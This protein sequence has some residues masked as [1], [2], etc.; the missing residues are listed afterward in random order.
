MSFESLTR[1]EQFTAFAQSLVGE[2]WS[3]NRIISASREMGF[4]IARSEALGIVRDAREAAITA[5]EQAQALGELPGLPGLAQ[6]KWGELAQQTDEWLRYDGPNAVLFQSTGAKPDEWLDYVILPEDQD[7]EVARF[8]VEDE[9]YID[10]ERPGSGYRT[11]Q[12]IPA[13]VPLTQ[14]ARRLGIN[15]NDI[16]RIIFD[17]A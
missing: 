6:P 1:T 5:Q 11:T 17:K 8:V 14:A 15:P 2:G 16:A 10:P 9:E 3:A 13:D 12:P 4:G 7:Y